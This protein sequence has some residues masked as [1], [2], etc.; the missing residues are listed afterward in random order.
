VG[1]IVDCLNVPR[2]DDPFVHQGDCL[3]EL[4][5]IHC[6]TS[7][8]VVLE[9]KLPGFEGEVVAIKDQ[10]GVLMALCFDDVPPH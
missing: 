3:S 4:A 6:C 10:D 2:L 5:G 8:D 9:E 1:F 7:L